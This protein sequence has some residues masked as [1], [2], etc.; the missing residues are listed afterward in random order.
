MAEF[1]DIMINDL[2][3]DAPD[4]PAWGGSSGTMIPEGWYQFRV[5]NATLDEKGQ[6]VIKY[7]VCN[8][9][10]QKG[11]TIQHW[12]PLSSTTGKDGWRMRLK[13]IIQALGL[14]LQNN[15]STATLLGLE[16]VAEVYKNEY[17]SQDAQGN[18]IVKSSMKVREELRVD[19]NQ[20]RAL[21]GYEDDPG[22]VGTSPGPANDI[23]VRQDS[24]VVPAGGAGAAGAVGAK[25]RMPVAGRP[26]NGNTARR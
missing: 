17:P 7:E 5:V 2:G 23:A 20:A 4:L 26:T 16:L 10:E 24:A 21:L 6:L 9:C 25:A 3:L 19:S 15:L 22:G 8:E 12:Q 13:N 18:P 14:P 11:K 1:V